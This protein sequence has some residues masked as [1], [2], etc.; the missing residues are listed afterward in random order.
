MLPTDAVS[1]QRISPTEDTPSLSMVH[2]Q[3][4]HIP[5]NATR[6]VNVHVPSEDTSTEDSVNRMTSDTTIFESPWLHSSISTHTL[7][8][9]MSVTNIGVDGSTSSGNDRVATV[10]YILVA[11]GVTIVIVSITL[12]TVAV[13]LA[14]K[15]NNKKQKTEGKVI[16]A[17][18]ASE[19]IYNS[20]YESHHVHTGISTNPRLNST[21]YRSHWSL[22][23]SDSDSIHYSYPSVEVGASYP[24]DIGC[25]T[26][27]HNRNGVMGSIGNREDQTTKIGE[28][29]EA[30]LRNVVAQFQGI[31][32]LQRIKCTAKEKATKR[33]SRSFTH[34]EKVY[35]Q[36]GECD[37]GSD[38]DNP[39]NKEEEEEKERTSEVVSVYYSEPIKRVEPTSIFLSENKAY[40]SR[41][42]VSIL[43]SENEAYSSRNGIEPSENE[44]YNARNPTSILVSE[45]EAYESGNSGGILAESRSEMNT[46][47]VY[48]ASPTGTSSEEF[49]VG[50]NLAYG[51]SPSNIRL[52]Q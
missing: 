13:I 42:P 49:E 11:V 10:I 2:T 30:C 4:S 35:S 28:T 20:S 32:Y 24:C 40:D 33:T 47:S 7:N 48:Y 38:Y 46:D 41:D 50:S 36:G 21:G 1:S 31:S 52:L 25:N 34:R 5:T 12:A 18:A 44:A 39:I 26:Q 29:S 45:N 23:H 17:R 37:E 51:T 9:S 15:Y 19:F 27:S 6:A 14:C 43:L 22:T 8:T 3:S 16:K